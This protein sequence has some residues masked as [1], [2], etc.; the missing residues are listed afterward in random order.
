MTV[1]RRDFVK[2]S[3]LAMAALAVPG[4]SDLLARELMP[5]QQATDLASRQ[6][7]MLALD[8]AR[9]AGAS[10][11]DA[12]VVGIRRQTVRT[13][14][15]RVSA[16][17][18]SDSL[19]LGIRVLVDGAWG[20]SASHRLT[21]PEAMTLARAAVEQAR[22]N[23]RLGGGDVQLAP[24]EAYPDGEWRSPI[25]ID[26]FEVTVED[27]IA[28]LLEANA[29]ALRV[30]RVRFVNSAIRA[31]RI[32]TTFASTAGSMIQQAVYRTYPSMTVTAVAPDRSGF[33]SRSSGEVA[34]MGLG[35]EY[36]ERVDLK[37]RAGPWAEEAA[38]KLTARS[39]EPGEYDLVL[40]PSHLFLT[41]HE[42]IGHATELDRA[43]GYEAGFA[44]TTFLAP[45]E[46]VLGKFRFGPEFMNV[47][48][49]RT[50]RGALATVG[51][52]D[53]GVAADSWPIVQDGV[54][55]DYQ[56]TR[57]QAR[58]IAEFTGNE[59]S[60]GCAHA[61]SWQHTQF[62]RMPNVSLLPGEEGHGLDD[63]IAATDRGIL[64]KGRGSYS[65]DQQRYN[66]QFGGQVFHEIKNGQI[67]GMLKDV[68]YQSRTP[69]FWNSLDMLGGPQ[70]YELGGTL[71][72]G[73]GQPPQSNAVSHGCPVARFRKVRVINTAAA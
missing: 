48:G 36:V 5:A 56:T 53:E 6:L 70:T 52:D 7:C 44:G 12:R 28:L 21:R 54:L 57:E 64:I 9:S 50:Q 39:V 38:A 62:Q 73:K 19:G 40:H 3:S 14:E 34:P 60:H 1:N 72:D 41:I 15:E 51:W 68:A 8:A 43:M 32:E 17:E 49:D 42:S 26:P 25:A 10:Y 27:K 63:L 22:V 46:S 20:F 2:T 61:E 4:G 24:I 65:I 69:D 35:Y 47:Q 11:A 29:E 31:E 30:D 66:F 23:A 13:R 71:S 58:W 37:E 33:E 67:V 45:P 55:V 16:V 18:E 59:R